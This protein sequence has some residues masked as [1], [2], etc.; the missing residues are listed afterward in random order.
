MI[1]LDA[2]FS[3]GALSAKIFSLG[4]IGLKTRAVKTGVF[5]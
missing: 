4:V 5:G 1:F 3:A 2:I